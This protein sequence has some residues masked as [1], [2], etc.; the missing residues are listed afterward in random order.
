LSDHQQEV[1]IESAR[2]LLCEIPGIS[3]SECFSA[4]FGGDADINSMTCKLV[5]D[6]GYKSILM[7]RQKFQQGL[8]GNDNLQ[9]LERFMPRDE[10]IIEELITACT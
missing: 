10:D 6:S 7:S 1:E 8:P 5:I 4:P 2:N 3:L 9:V